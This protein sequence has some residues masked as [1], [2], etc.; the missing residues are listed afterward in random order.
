MDPEGKGS[1]VMPRGVISA[2][3]KGRNK[4]ASSRPCFWDPRVNTCALVHVC[5]SPSPGPSYGS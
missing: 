3:P 1:S 2:Y 5:I 4:R